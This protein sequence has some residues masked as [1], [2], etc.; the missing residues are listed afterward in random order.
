MK[1]KLLTLLAVMLLVSGCAIAKPKQQNI[2][3]LPLFHLNQTKLTDC[4][5]ELSNLLGMI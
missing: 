2:D 3:V 4:G 1:K 5:L